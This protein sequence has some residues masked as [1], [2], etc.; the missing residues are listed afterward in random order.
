MTST[1]TS[2]G[3]VGRR[4]GY[5][6]AAIVNAALLYAVHVWPTWESVGFLT[7][8][9]VEVLGV[10]SATMLAA[11]VANLGYAVADPAWLRALGDLVTTGVGIAALLALWQVFPFD[12]GETSFDW[13]L[14]VRWMLAVGLVG[15][16]I[17][18]LVA[19]GRLGR[20]LA[21]HHTRTHPR[22]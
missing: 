4:A 8:D 15:S 10:V 2:R 17:A 5:V 9:T 22:V 11:V 13:A 1:S 19:A 21:V 3:A 18:M 14:L 20:A 12:F 7:G 6:V 16:A